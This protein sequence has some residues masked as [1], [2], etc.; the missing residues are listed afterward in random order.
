MD[1]FKELIKKLTPFLKSLGFSKK[2]NSFHL[3]LDKNYGII[4]F[5]K[6]RESTEDVLKFTINFG[7]Y[8]NVLGQSEYDY[9]NLSKPE[10]EQCQWNSRVGAF[11]PNSPDYWWI[12]NFTDDLNT[13]TQ[14]LVDN[15]QN[16]IIPEINKRLSDEGLI[17]SWLNE[18][19]AG[20]TEIGRFKY[21]T[22]LLK[23]K[24]DFNTLN[25]IIETSMQQMKGK[26]NAKLA[27]EH[28]KEIDVTYQS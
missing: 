5:Q 1:I 2:G 12:I 6:S 9:N 24:G 18:N 13:Y 4:N 10:I 25:H 7:I 27:I 16:I 28:L 26:P 21:L 14:D 17:N 3:E 22:T 20:T 23:I 11:M 8:S 19:N 15:I